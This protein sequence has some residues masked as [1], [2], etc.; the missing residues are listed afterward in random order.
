VLSLL[1]VAYFVNSIFSIF[2]SRLAKPFWS[3]GLLNG[4]KTRKSRLIF[5]G[6]PRAD[7]D[8]PQSHPNRRTRPSC[9][10]RRQ[11]RQVHDVTAKMSNRLKSF[12]GEVR[13]TCDKRHFVGR[14]LLDPI[15][16]RQIFLSILICVDGFVS[17]LYLYILSSMLYSHVLDR[18]EIWR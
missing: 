18:Y 12:G 1:R 11:R 17:L 16:Y 14:F 2:V 8:H 7:A 9:R 13:T 5:S 15:L 4:S 6:W 3:T 10:Q